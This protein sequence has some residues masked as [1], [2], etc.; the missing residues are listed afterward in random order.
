MNE[1]IIPEP[2]T[3][4][5]L[6]TIELE[7]QEILEKAIDGLIKKYENT[8]VTAETIKESKSS[9][10]EL[11]KL[12]T[13]LDTKRKNDKKEF[14][15]PL[16]IYETK[17]KNLKVKVKKCSDDIGFQIKDFEKKEREERRDKV[18]TLINEMAE[19]YQVDPE[20]IEIQSKWLNKT[21]SKKSIIDGIAGAMQERKRYNDD[22]AIV[23]R[24]AK[25][26]GME[27]YVDQYI[28][29]LDTTSAIDIEQMI[30]EDVERKQQR[31]EAQKAAELARIEAKKASSKQVGNK[32][33]DMETGE[34][35]TLLQEITF[36]I[37]GTE[38]QINQLAR[39]VKDSGLQ[40]VKSSERKEVIQK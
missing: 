26:K 20:E 32:L 37:R 16:E 30:D 33:I 39:F 19:N 1:L 6:G 25:A 22:K 35:E 13:A 31:E 10:A 29:L 2:K 7:N 8:V 27:L 23:E 5:D 34:T 40:V 36:T 15:E 18:I 17:I 3:T 9:R 4:I 21:A 28:K 38:E 12:A 11:N 14:L 24:Y